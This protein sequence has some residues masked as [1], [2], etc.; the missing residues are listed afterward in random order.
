M[1]DDDEFAPPAPRKRFRWVR[2]IALFMLIGLGIVALILLGGRWQLGRLGERRLQVESAR[3]DQDDPNWKL[4]AVLAERDK[5]VPDAANSAP[6]VLKIAEQIPEDWKKWRNT[7]DATKWWP[8]RRDNRLPPPDLTAGA[9]KH[10]ADTHLVR[11]EA[12][13]LRDTRGGRF[14][15][16]PNPN[17]L[18]ILLPHLNECRTVASLLQYDAYL[19]AIDKNPNRAVSAARAVLAVSRAV[20]DEPFLVSQLVRMA[21]ASIAAQTA[22]Q[23][24]AWGEPADG[25][26]ELQRELWAEADVPFFR[27]GM[28]GERASLDHLFRGLADGSIPLEQALSHGADQRARPEQAAALRVYRPLIPG[29]HAKMLEITSKYVEA[30]HRPHHE[31]LAAIKAVP[32]PPAPPDDFRYLLTRLSLPA[33]D[34]MAEAGLRARA[35]L[36]AAA[37][38]VACERFRQKHKR[39]PNDPTELVPA[40]LPAVPLNP[41]DG[42]PVNYRTF[43]D[44]IAIYFYWADSPRKADDVPEEF[45]VGHPPGAA[46]GLRLWNPEL[47]GLAAEE[48]KDP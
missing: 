40:F 5:A 6:T 30:S 12:I 22:A 7:E 26:E 8:S 16:A 25:L 43:G 38:G 44:R 23:V 14:T 24:L 1:T 15:I 21:C 31:Q 4:D 34:R 2:K 35:E 20:G 3:L 9:R 10:A 28:R 18:A 17:P 41:F 37:T 32:I 39:W 48:K 33:C 19:A 36:L 27:I 45:R 46:Y 47:R 13:R 29:D 11:T 42:K